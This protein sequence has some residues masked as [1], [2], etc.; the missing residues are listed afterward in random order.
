MKLAEL[1]GLPLISIFHDWYPDASGCP[2]GWTWVWDQWFRKLYQR[3]ALAF[4]VSPGMGREL[5]DHPNSHLLP[6]I[7]ANSESFK[8]KAGDS[9]L[10]PADSS[11]VRLYYAGHSGGLYAPMLRELIQ[12]VQGDERFQLRISGSETAQLAEF[13]QKGKVEVLGF[14]NGDEWQ[15]AFEEADLLLVVLPFEKRRERHLRTHFPSKLVEYANRGR[16]ILIWGPE[17]SSA[18][19]WAR[20]ASNV[21]ICTSQHVEALLETAAEL[22][23]PSRSG[24]NGVV[25]TTIRDEKIR[26]EP[27]LIHKNFEYQLKR[28]AL[29]VS[30]HH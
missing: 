23:V 16:P 13:S 6:P 27:E 17:T 7:P 24:R 8:A 3:S 19:S 28:L 14:L 12:A 26:F 4:V 2:K 25:G 21:L 10:T 30:Q 15:R 1:S 5:G 29:G 22:A 18:V 20:D 11:R 9:T